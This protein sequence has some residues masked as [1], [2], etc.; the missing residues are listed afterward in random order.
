MFLAPQYGWEVRRWLSPPPTLQADGS[1]LAAENETLAAQ[2]AELQGVAAQLPSTSPHYLLAMVYSRYPLN[3]KSELLVNAGAG[4]GVAVGKAVVFQGILV[5]TI[6]KV[7]S[8]SSLIQT[9]FD[10][11]FKMPVRVGALGYDAL[12]LGGA[13]PRVTSL[14][15]TAKVKA[16]DIV[17]TAAEG[18]PYGLPVA[19]VKSTSTSPD[20]LFEE[21]V[22]DFAYDANS[23][24]TVFISR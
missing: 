5:G 9:V 20:N 10:G 2:L 8:D 7:F 18:L 13:S 11:N 16:G 21:A 4:D 19:L 23:V 14:A 1:S 6:E 12:L 15:K 3:F 17:Y 22:L 24:E